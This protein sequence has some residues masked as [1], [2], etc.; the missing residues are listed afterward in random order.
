MARKSWADARL[1]AQTSSFDY[2]KS[3]LTI[4]SGQSSVEI[5]GVLDTG[6]DELDAGKA[7]NSDGTFPF[8]AKLSVWRDDL[9]WLPVKNEEM[10]IKRMDYPDDERLY[11]V[12]TVDD[13][14]DLL[15]IELQA[16]AYNGRPF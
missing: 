3:L 10:R 8:F 2:F 15:H 12:E 1:A 13:S 5:Y 11:L 7:M 6:I 16:Q 4:R 9:G 14:S